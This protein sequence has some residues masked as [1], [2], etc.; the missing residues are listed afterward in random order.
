MENMELDPREFIFPPYIK[1]PNCGKESFGILMI[2]NYHYCRR[3]KECFFPRRTESPA[4]YPLPQL[5]KKII[6]LDQFAISNMMKA[7]N[8]QTNAFQKGTIDKFWI[9]LF[10]RVDSLCKLQLIVCPYSDIHEEES[11]LFSDFYESLKQM[12]RLLS[13][14][15]SFYDFNYIERCQIYESAKSWIFG[16]DNKFNI[17][18]KQAI[19][20]EINVWHGRFIISVN[21]RNDEN[22]ENELRK[23]REKMHDGMTECFQ[24]WQSEKDKT[25]DDWFEEERIGYGSII[26]QQYQDY[27]EK[28][29][30]ESILGKL[31]TFDLINHPQSYD[32]VHAIHYAF[33]EAGIVDFELLRS[34][35]NEFLCSYFFKEVP[36]V[37]ISSLFFASIARKAEMGMKKRPNQGMI[38]DIKVIS[39]L[40]PYCDAMFIDNECHAYLSEQPL[41][42]RINYG[43][44]IF[45]QKTKE[46]FIEYLDEIESN[47]SI[48]HFNKIKE[49]YG[50]DWDKPYT[51]LYKNIQ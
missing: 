24:R 31:N 28:C 36:F 50:D 47:T 25:F 6:Y 35:T 32:L 27:I 29:Y 33:E 37:K 46:E 38:N 20:G 44:A 42:D 23:V 11:F 15:L 16:K 10:E 40:L 14:N 51:N 21:I 22:W 17:D 45:S 30:R 5:D 19:Q 8:P 12:Y 2:C 41:K 18:R 13:H 43:T 4:I 9:R 1:C 49:V 7:L 34:K 3:C 39:H 26:L 48:E